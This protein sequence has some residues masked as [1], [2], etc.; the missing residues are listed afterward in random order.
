MIIKHNMKF[1]NVFNEDHTKLRA[2]YCIAFEQHDMKSSHLP[3]FFKCMERTNE[4]CVIAR[5]ERKYQIYIVNR[6][7]WTEQYI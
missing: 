7:E 4:H 1:V 6:I 5:N 3:D 2:G